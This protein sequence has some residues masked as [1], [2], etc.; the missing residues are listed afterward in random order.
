MES[1]GPP[2][3]LLQVKLIAHCMNAI[4]LC[5]KR[6]K[7]TATTQALFQLSWCLFQEVLD[8]FGNVEAPKPKLVMVSAMQLNPFVKELEHEQ[9][10]IGALFHLLIQRFRPS[11]YSKEVAARQEEACKVLRGLAAVAWNP[12]N[13]DL[14]QRVMLRNGSSSRLRLLSML[15]TQ[16]LPLLKAQ[17]EREEA[18]S[19]LRG[20]VLLTSDNMEED[21][22]TTLAR[23]VAH[24]VWCLV[25]DFVGGLL[26]LQANESDEV[27][28]WDFMS[29]AESL[30]LAAVEPSSSQR[31]THAIV[32]E[33]QSL[34]RLLSALSGSASRRKHWRQ[35]LP[36]NAVVLMEQSRQIVRRAC[37][38]L[39]SSSTEIS[40]R[41]KERTQK[42]KSPS[43]KSAA[44]LSLIP[45]SPRSPRSPSAFSYAHQTLLHD[46]LQAARDV[47]KRNLTVFHR[48]METELVEIVRLTSLLL[49]KWTSSLTDRDAILVVNSVRYVDEEQLVPLLAFI[50][51]AKRAR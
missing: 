10:G 47:E 6:L 23:S 5:D 50:P 13:A 8:S 9:E 43:N 44:V 12:D 32:A 40:R 19:N 37:V 16:L 46:H 29:H 39:G 48:A 27:D 14:C 4:T 22:E 1:V 42:A 7:P 18:T 35:A 24:R 3:P 41:R 36:S 20:Y 17:M 15:A 49:T 30:L 51:L 11:S 34:L 2:K 38:L 45:K 25:L 31:L 21:Q 26:R 28:V 33:H